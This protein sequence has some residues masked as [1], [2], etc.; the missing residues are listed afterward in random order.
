ML[1]HPALATVLP[2]LLA[3]PVLALDHSGDVAG[4]WLASDSPHDVVGNALVPAGST[5]VIE[6][7][8]VV[9]FMAGTGL[10][11]EGILQAGGP[12]GRVTMDSATLPGLPGDWRGI[13]LF[14]ADPSVMTS[15]DMRNARVAVTVRAH[16]GLEASDVSVDA[17][18][19]HGI[20]F[21]PGSFGTLQDCRFTGNGMAGILIATAS[22]RVLDCSFTGNV[23]PITLIGSSGP[24]FQGL[25]ASGNAEGDAIHVDPAWSIDDQAVWIDGGLPYLIPADGSLVIDPLG[26]LA[27]AA[28]TVVKLGARAGIRVNGELW[29]SGT[30]TQPC[31]L[32]S[33]A[34]DSAGGDT[35][36]DGGATTP[37][38]GDWDAVQV[39]SGG[40]ALVQA[41]EIRLGRDGIR[42][43]GG[44][45][46]LY[47]ADVHHALDRGLAFGPGAE[48]V[49]RE[50]AIHDCDVGV[51]VA[52]ASLVGMG[53][54]GGGPDAG[55]GNSI[56]C[57]VSLDVQSLNESSALLALHNWW[58]PA[59]P[60]PSRL[61]GWIDASY[62]SVSVPP[63]LSES[64]VLR[65]SRAAPDDIR[66]SW[67]ESTSC[68]SLSAFFAREPNGFFSPAGASTDETLILPL[69]SQPAGLV[70]YVVE[71]D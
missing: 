40:L 47:R 68:D 44:R 25:T 46:V 9:R 10:T 63:F 59:G 5:L 65:V 58:G 14:G 16:A 23:R 13:T 12:G 36:G 31:L 60:D 62:E 15:V 52:E 39:E 66:L 8:C 37:T 27:I 41:T 48:G 7:G 64:R 50:S 35:N 57:N 2:L 26:T 51:Q 67:N 11:V 19:L 4:T 18:L 71:I 33:L 43:L 24:D 29:A 6:P 30:L 53:R 22:P 32:T 20:A 54:P 17:S 56:T 45:S 69:A 49:I 55:G 42:S 38:K 1:R 70:F 3:T 21:L 28:G 61:S 34:D